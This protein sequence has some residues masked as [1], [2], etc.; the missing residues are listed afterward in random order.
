MPITP[1]IPEVIPA[2]PEKVINQYWLKQLIINAPSLT[3][4]AEA[5]VSLVP[6]NNTTGEMF[7]EL[8][9]KFV[10][11]DILTKAA[12]DTDLAT[13]CNALFSTIDRLAKAQEV[14]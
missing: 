7:P 1:E 2:I 10:V 13:T 5:I 8:E 12:T 14:I 3:D 11:D 4:K 9:V 6:Y